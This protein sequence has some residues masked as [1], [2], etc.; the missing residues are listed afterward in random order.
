MRD[1]LVGGEA[2]MRSGEDGEVEEGKIGDNC[3]LKKK[4]VQSK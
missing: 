3:S 2:E 4:E 1:G